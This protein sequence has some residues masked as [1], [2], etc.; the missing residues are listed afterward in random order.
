V[1]EKLEKR[2]MGRGKPA[3]AGLVKKMP[4]GATQIIHYT[5]LA[6]SLPS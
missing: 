3:A 1:N 2:T 4:G 5:S 6:H